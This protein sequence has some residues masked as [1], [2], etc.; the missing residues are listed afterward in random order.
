ML[1]MLESGSVGGAG[2]ES[3]SEDSMAGM[4][5]DSIERSIEKETFFLRPPEADERLEKL[6]EAEI[7]RLW[8]GGSSSMGELTM[9]DRA[10][11]AGEENTESAEEWTLEVMDAVEWW[12]VVGVW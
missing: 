12:D 10:E 7:V 9:E 8:I 2:K 4:I 1:V 5:S 3:R 6:D 11:F